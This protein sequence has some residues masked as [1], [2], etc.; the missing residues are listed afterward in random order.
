MGV[1][2]ALRPDT[3]RLGFT[4][5]R[6]Y[7]RTLLRLFSLLSELSE[8]P[9]GRRRLCLE[10]QE[11]L[12]KKIKYI[13]GRVRACRASI[14]TLR[15]SLASHLAKEDARDAKR[16]LARNKRT[17]VGYRQVLYLLHS[18]G[19]ALPYLY[20]SPW[21]L[22]PL[23]FKERPGF[24]TGKSGLRLEIR[25]VRALFGAGGVAI[26]NDITNSLRYGDVTFVR[27]DGSFGLIEAKSGSTTGERGR[28]Q[29]K[30]L[31][32]MRR[33]L[34]DD[35][36][37]GLYSVPGPVRR[38]AV[39]QTPTHHRLLIRAMMRSA[40]EEAKARFQ[41]AEEGLWYF[42]CPA[43]RSRA[44]TLVS[45]IH[46]NVSVPWLFVL[47]DVKF[48]LQG[49]YPFTLSI[50]DPDI[51]FAL[52]AGDVFVVV[53]LD[54]KAIQSALHSVGL[55]AVVHDADDYVLKV[56]RIGDPDGDYIKVSRH[57]LA[58]VPVEFLS[59]SWL[60]PEISRMHERL[61]DVF[62]NGGSAQLA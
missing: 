12:L 48:S 50:G 1:S 49:H 11:A 41:R 25:I 40:I 55:T 33:Y 56:H 46:D 39:N 62:E 14:A 2:Q 36:T 53:V 6:R 61:G 34:A 52:Y 44:E 43:A 16:A 20:I 45:Y 23:G 17:L 3:G 35:R 21:D 24:V 10:T 60:I 18:V 54:L 59:L 9:L 31:E 29:H 57:L 32:K 7:G 58:R 13:E 4:L 30:A 19:D 37:V 8:D 27:Q 42:V 51:L 38:V 22:K 26:L 15:R 28:R 47:N 5:I